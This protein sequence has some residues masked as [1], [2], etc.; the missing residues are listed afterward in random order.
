LVARSNI[1]PASGSKERH[2]NNAR[3]YLD[4]IKQF[5]RS[6]KPRVGKFICF[7]Y[8]FHTNPY[9]IDHP[10]KKKYLDFQP[11]DLVI[12]V[13]PQKGT[14]MCVNFH[15]LPVIT[16]QIFLAK[17]KKDYTANFENEDRR[18]TV[19]PGINYKKLFKYLKKIGVAVRCYRFERVMSLREVPVDMIDETM[20]FYA[21]FYYKSNYK[22]I[23]T[24]Y[25]DY[26]PNK[27]Q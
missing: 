14:F 9:Y 11:F 1:N 7:T 20:K 16:R 21:N 27:P 2:Y 22:A 13:R 4:F 17:L 23:V 24:R 3:T 26:T 15:H 12:A 6:P 18:R 25:V 19:I 8:N 10:E 5:P